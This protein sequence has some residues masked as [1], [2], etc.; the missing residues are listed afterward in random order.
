VRIIFREIHIYVL[1]VVPPVIIISF[2]VLA[3]LVSNR[4]NRITN[5]TD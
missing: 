1:N 2:S 5:S 3:I 4:A